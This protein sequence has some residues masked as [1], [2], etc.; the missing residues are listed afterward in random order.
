IVSR[1]E[2]IYANDGFTYQVGKDGLPY[3]LKVEVDIAPG[4]VFTGHIDKMPMDKQ[5]RIWDLDHKSHKRIPDADARYHDIQQ[6]FYQWAAPLSGY[7][8]LSGVVWDYI[9]TKPP[10]IPEW[11]KRG[12]LSQRQNMDT[13]FET[14]M[15]EV[16]RHNLDPADYAETPNRLKARGHIDF[17]Q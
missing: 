15:A 16:Q 14:Y 17:Y 5:G 1:Y 13:D 3:E 6:V 12:G 10:T 11:L 7:A 2:L 4:I 8:K 9:R